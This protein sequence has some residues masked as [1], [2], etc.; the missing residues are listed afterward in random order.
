MIWLQNCKIEETT[1]KKKKSIN[2]SEDIW[3][4]SDWR[5]KVTSYKNKIYVT[6]QKVSV[7]LFFQVNYSKAE[8]G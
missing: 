5:S 2:F 7:C 4:S 3:Q 1:C 8:V 6:L